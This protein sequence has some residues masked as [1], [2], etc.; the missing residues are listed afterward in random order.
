[1]ITEEKNGLHIVI[2]NYRS[3]DY[4]EGCLAK[5]PSRLDELHISV[6]VVDNNSEEGPELEA[7]QQKYEWIQFL[8]NKKN[9][10]FSIACNQGIKSR[11]ADL[12][13]LLNPDTVINNKALA[14]CSRFLRQNP[15]AG[16]TSCRIL[17]PDG[18]EQKAGRRN[19]PTPTSAFLHF[20][21]LQKIFG[22]KSRQQG[23]H[24]SGPAGDHPLEVEA[25]SGSFLMFRKDV[26]QITGG[27]DETFFM[28]GEDL[29]FCLRARQA[30]WLA[31]YLP[32]TS[33]LHYKRVS[34]SRS[35][36]PANLHFYRA[37]EIFYRKH[38]YKDA[39]WISR[40]AVLT[41]IRFLQA[42][43]AIRIRLTG[44]KKVGSSG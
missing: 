24:P 1:M 25:V 29:D 44:N 39:A 4:L 30:G 33:V 17:N 21:G 14:E 37:M 28:Y 26:L 41:G 6:T 7:L 43:S 2:V 22:G 31:Y 42:F 34:S 32:Y 10:G 9:L 3:S 18:T 15:Q 11:D 38:Y 35:A 12:Y 20:T 13:L 27:L 5:I 19:I 16:I 40:A 8:F 23:Y 36:G